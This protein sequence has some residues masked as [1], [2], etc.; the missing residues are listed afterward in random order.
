MRWAAAVCGVLLLAGGVAGA[1]EPRAPGYTGVDWKGYSN[2]DIDLILKLERIAGM[3]IG[4]CVTAWQ[5]KVPRVAGE[6]MVSGA[7]DAADEF[8]GGAEFVR[9]TVNGVAQWKEAC[10]SYWPAEYKYR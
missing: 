9:K 6:A 2:R 8:P 4:T 7:L 5:L 3:A 10:R 1:E